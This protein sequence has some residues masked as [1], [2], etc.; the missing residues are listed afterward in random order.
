MA[1]VVYYL[2]YSNYYFYKAQDFSL[3][4]TITTNSNL[5]VINEIVIEK[6]IK[7]CFIDITRNTLKLPQD[8]LKN[9][10]LL[11]IIAIHKDKS[12]MLNETNQ[13]VVFEFISKDYSNQYYRDYITCDFDK[14]KILTIY[15]NQQL[16]Y[17]HIDNCLE[18]QYIYLNNYF[19][20]QPSKFFGASK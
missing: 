12:A 4:N 15:I 10:K 17:Q 18:K 9:F 20:L 3:K 2:Y 14:Y 11:D 8:I 19:N 13:Q 5:K 7:N 1:Y 6:K 16:L